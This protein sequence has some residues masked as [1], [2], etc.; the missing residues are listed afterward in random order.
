ML[1]MKR[2]VITLLTIL[3]LPANIV[4]GDAQEHTYYNEAYTLEK[5]GLFKGSDIGYE[6]EREPNRLESGV[7]LIRMLGKEE[8]AL[9]GDW[10]H[11]FQDVP[12]WG[13]KYV[14][15]LYSKGLSKGINQNSFGSNVIIDAKSY[16]TFLLRA[17]GYDD[18]K[19]DFQWKDALDKAAEIG[20]VSKDESKELSLP[21]F[22]RGD[23]AYLSY[24]SLFS[25]LKEMDKTLLKVLSDEG[26]ISTSVE[27]RKESPLAKPKFVGAGVYFESEYNA[28]PPESIGNSAPIPV[29]GHTNEDLSV[30]IYKIKKGSSP[31]NIDGN[32]VYFRFDFSLPEKLEENSIQLTIWSSAGERIGTANYSYSASLSQEFN[33]PSYGWETDSIHVSRLISFEDYGFITLTGTAQGLDG[34][35]YPIEL[36]M[37]VVDKV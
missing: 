5:L 23:M 29:G 28:P 1:K 21:G 7:M 11:P 24:S 30:A 10:S 33:N 4:Y 19:G 36:R 18:S 25:N 31:L 27:L 14:G 17:L 12:Q 37:E 9:D 35:I 32:P 15:Y 20:I 6:L 13:Q 34:E 26:V 8:E 22:T 2:L 3:L 16:A